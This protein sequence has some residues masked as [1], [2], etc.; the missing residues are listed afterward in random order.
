MRSMKYP[1]GW[2]KKAKIPVSSGNAFLDCIA[3]NHKSGKLY[4]FECKR[5]HASPDGSAQ[6]SIDSRLD[7]IKIS[8]PA[9]LSSVN[10]N[11]KSFD[12]F[13]LS[14]Y[15]SVWN[16]KYKIFDRA[17]IASIFEPCVGLFM[18]EY[19]RYIEYIVRNMYSSRIRTEFNVRGGDADADKDIADEG[20]SIFC[21]LEN[22]PKEIEGEIQFTE[23]KAKLVPISSDMKK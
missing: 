1:T 14:F 20:D 22:E 5:G 12:L 6:K 4:V 10:W 23:S 11:P 19:M 15:G 9:Y 16:S 13:I 7:D 2:Q 17:S 8:I 21:K 3:F 18:D